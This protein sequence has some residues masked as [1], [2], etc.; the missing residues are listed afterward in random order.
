M[1]AVDGQKNAELVR[2]I[3]QG[4]RTDQSFNAFFSVVKIK[5]TEQD[6]NEPSLRRNRRAPRRLEIGTA[7]PEFATSVENK[8]RQIYLEQLIFVWQQLKTDLISQGSKL[9]CK[10][11]V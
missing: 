7:N 8:Y 1:A 3:L 4:M 9:T 5:A 2:S 10:W 6:V 11:R